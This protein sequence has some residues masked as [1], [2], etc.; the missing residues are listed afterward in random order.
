ME[1]L[2]NLIKS[3]DIFSFK[4]HLTINEKGETRYKNLLGGFLSLNYFFTSL[5]FIIYF[6]YKLLNKE[7]LNVIYS[8]EKD[9]FVNFTYANKLPIMVRL[10]DNNKRALN[11]EKLYNISLKIWYNFFNEK[12][13]DYTIE[14]YNDIILEQCDL[15]KHFGEYKKYF[16]KIKNINTYYCPFERLTNQT[17]FG[18]YGQNSN[19]SFYYY[20]FSKC[21]FNNCYTEEEINKTLSHVYLD[22]IF[23]DY[24]INHLNKKKPNKLLIKSERIMTSSTIYKRINLYFR[25][26]KYITD[27]GIFFQ[28]IKKDYFHQFDSLRFDSDIRDIDNSE[29]PRTFLTLSISNSAEISV[30]NRKYLKFQDYLVNICGIIK[31]LNVAFYFL[32]YHF[33]RNSYYIRIIKDFLIENNQIEKKNSKK[34]INLDFSSLNNSASNFHKNFALSYSNLQLKLQEKEIVEK[35]FKYKCLPIKFNF[36]NQND[37]AV[38]EKCIRIIN[39]RLNIIRILNKI[40]II[41]N[42]KKENQN[43][44]S[45]PINNSNLLNNIDSKD[46]ESNNINSINASFSSNKVNNFLEEKKNNS[47]N[48]LSRNVK[49]KI[50]SKFYHPK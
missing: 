36:R 35:K 1:S 41:E 9:S 27:N 42:L 8:I 47:M 6:M 15:N 50:I 49:K 40:E 39:N 4:T 5:C 21:S 33:A 18:V 31:T 23:I 38:I 34:K 46:K 7:D 11:T 13:N 10:S 45:Y 2:G 24:S 26:I 3:L 19:Y 44:N 28:K 12:L 32:N 37:F 14:I 30:Y 25:Q 20:Y 29:E 22:L 16:E 48:Y 43:N 17:L